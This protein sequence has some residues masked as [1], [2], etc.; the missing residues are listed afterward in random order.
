MASNITSPIVSALG[1]VSNFLS[2]I[3]NTVSNIS[4]NIL[5]GI[6]S[7]FQNLVDNVAGILEFL[8]DFFENLLDF[9]IHIFV[10][11][12]EQWEEI[13]ENQKSIGETAKA[14]LPFISLFNNEYKKAQETVSQTD[15]LVITIPEFSFS[16]VGI[17]INSRE[18]KVI[19]VRD[20]YEPYR[21]YVRNLLFFIVIAC[22]FV[23]LIK[24][25]LKF[26]SVYNESSGGG[27]EWLYIYY[28][29]YFIH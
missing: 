11:T 4:T 7:F 3:F 16:A 9:F 26:T 15:F 10:P 13:T 28:L 22:A 12:D 23:F 24:H 2:N 17:S 20:K 5:N 14:H 25:V 29:S 19:N 6:K 8:G 18:Q 21:A 27:E 1:S